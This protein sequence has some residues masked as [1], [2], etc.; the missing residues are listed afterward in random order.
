[1]SE[2]QHVSARFFLVNIV[3]H[4]LFP[5]EEMHRIRNFGLTGYIAV[6]VIGVGEFS[7]LLALF[8]AMCNR[9]FK[10]RRELK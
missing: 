3:G 2:R 8:L 5:N 10:M 9:L 4:Y 6:L 1:M 7:V